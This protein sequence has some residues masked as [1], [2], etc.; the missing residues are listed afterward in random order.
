M[1]PD[2]M[3]DIDDIKLL[4]LKAIDFNEPS[5]NAKKLERDFLY[6]LC[7]HLGHFTNCSKYRVTGIE[8]GILTGGTKSGVPPT[9][10]W[11]SLLAVHS[12]TMS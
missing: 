10:H 3:I 12:V 7:N 1:K 4:K 9:C 6:Y 8:P 2:K 5:T 11:S